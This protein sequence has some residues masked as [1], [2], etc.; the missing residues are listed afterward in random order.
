MKDTW[1]IRVLYDGACPLCTREVRLL[2][3]LDRER[4]RIGFED[5]SRAT[6]DSSVCGLDTVELMA[7]ING[8]LPDGTIVEGVEVFRRAYA[9]V[10]LGWLMAPTRWPVLRPLADLAYRIFARKR[11]RWTGRA[12]ACE[13]GQYEAAE[14]R[15]R[16]GTTPGE[17]EPEAGRVRRRSAGLGLGLLA[18]LAACQTAN[19]PLGV[20][21]EIDLDRYTGRWYEIASFPQRFQRGCVATTASYTRLDDGRIRVENECR[22]GSFDGDLRRAEGVAW[23]ADPNGSQAKLKV[24]FFWPFRGAY[25]VIELDPDYRYAVVGHPS[26]DYLWILARTQTL[27]PEIYETLLARIAAHGYDLERLNRTPQIERRRLR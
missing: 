5:I 19:P 7:R 26:R 15:A 18:M 24:Q 23:V 13:A 6:F 9:A 16:A 12:S 10:G 3:R 2:E 1:Q 22:D 25:W 27:D 8:V 20:V 14:T 17:R 21:D 11:L 4:G